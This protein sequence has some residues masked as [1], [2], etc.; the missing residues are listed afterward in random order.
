MSI[1]EEQSCQ[2]NSTQLDLHV[3]SKNIRM[4]LGFCAALNSLF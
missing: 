1:R 2:T 3:L 4:L